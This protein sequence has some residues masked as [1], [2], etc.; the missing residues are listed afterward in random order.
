GRDRALEHYLRLFLRRRRIDARAA[1]RDRNDQCLSECSG[2]NGESSFHDFGSLGSGFFVA[3]TS[4]RGLGLGWTIFLVAI[5]GSG[6]GGGG[7]SGFGGGSGAG[8]GCATTGSGAGAGGAGGGAGVGA[9]GVTA[10]ATLVWTTPR[11]L[12][13]CSAMIVAINAA[14]ST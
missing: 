13:P 7:G 12:P 4:G 14:A 9:G 2:M 8:A 5:L 6:F 11:A 1:Q 10:G 3:L